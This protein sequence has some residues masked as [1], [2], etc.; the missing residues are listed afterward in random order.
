MRPPVTE[1]RE[2]KEILMSKAKIAAFVAALFL[3]VSSSASAQ[4]GKKVAAHPT[5]AQLALWCRNHPA[6]TGDC[7]DVRSDTRGIR[8]DRKDVRTDRKDLRGDIKGGD[9]E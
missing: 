2:R 7:K 4:A 6:A 8:A 9:Q 1:P 3:A 5:R